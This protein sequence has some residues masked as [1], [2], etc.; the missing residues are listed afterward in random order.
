M[1]ILTQ[2]ASKR[3][4][5]A[6]DKAVNSHTHAGV[7]R[8]A[9]TDSQVRGNATVGNVTPSMMPPSTYLMS[10]RVAGLHL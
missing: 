7:V 6:P 5:H 8:N 4:R 9:A 3:R 10:P 1:P 2:G